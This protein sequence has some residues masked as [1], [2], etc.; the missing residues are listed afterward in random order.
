MKV[1]DGLHSWLVQE[2]IEVVGAQASIAS[3]LPSEND[4]WAFAKVEL[5]QVGIRAQDGAILAANATEGWNTV[6]QG[7]TQCNG[8]AT[9]V[10]PQ[11]V[12]VPVKEEGYLYINALT[13]GK[14]AGNS[15]FDYEIVVFYTKGRSR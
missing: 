13:M 15:M 7:I 4:G 11:G 2:D 5:S 9:I 3:L 14:S 10:F 6:P 12:A 8:H 1:S